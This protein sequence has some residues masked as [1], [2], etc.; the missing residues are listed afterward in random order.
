MAI[1]IDAIYL[2]LHSKYKEQYPH[3]PDGVLRNHL[4]RTRMDLGAGIIYLAMKNGVSVP[5]AERLMKE[6]A[7]IEEA[8]ETLGRG[9][10][11]DPQLYSI[12]GAQLQKPSGFQRISVAECDE[13]PAGWR[14][15]LYGRVMAIFVG[16]ALP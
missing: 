14:I 5:D 9:A 1:N 7:T 13:H 2:E 4:Y 15:A 11:V 8:S 6:G 3:N 16:G 12:A 10:E